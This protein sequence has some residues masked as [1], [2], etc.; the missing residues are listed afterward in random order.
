MPHRHFLSSQAFL[1]YL[2]SSGKTGA[3]VNLAST[4]GVTAAPNS[5]AYTASKHAVV[6]LTKE[7]A[8]EFGES[9]IRINAVAPGVTRTSLIER[10]FQEAEMAQTL[11]SLHAMGR[12]GEAEEI[13]K[14]ILFLASGDASFITGETLLVDGTVA[15]S[16]GN[17]CRVGPA[18]GRS[19][20]Y[21]YSTS[22]WLFSGALGCQIGF[23]SAQAIRR[24]N[25][26]TLVHGLKFWGVVRN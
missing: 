1:R 21:R 22:P 10:Y 13:A 12:W 16:L 24:P 4:L 9:G 23:Q 19:G 5:A 14:A 8:L 20:K 3:V 18:F 26:L 17:E 15:G 25:F 2:T 11:R 7:M 6:G